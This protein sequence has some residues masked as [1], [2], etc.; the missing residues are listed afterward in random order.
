LPEQNF[1]ASLTIYIGYDNDLEKVE[2]IAVEVTKQVL[3]EMGLKKGNPSFACK[4]FG[5][6]AITCSISF[7]V[8]NLG[9]QYGIKHML[10]KRLHSR[11]QKENIAISFPLNTVLNQKH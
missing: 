6:T 7:T 2:K 4:D 11:F 1:S 10:I 9:E 3:D 8:Q 5:T